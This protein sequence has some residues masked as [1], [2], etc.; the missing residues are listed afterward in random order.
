M[1]R[2]KFKEDNVRRWI[3]L[4]AMGVGEQVSY[5]FRKKV[6]QT[7]NN[8]A[9]PNRDSTSPPPRAIAPPLLSAATPCVSAPPPRLRP[10]TPRALAPPCAL[11]PP[12]QGLELPPRL[13]R[14]PHHT[15]KVTPNVLATPPRL[16]S[17][18][19]SATLCIPTPWLWERL[20]QPRGSS[21]GAKPQARRLGDK[22]WPLWRRSWWRRRPLR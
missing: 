5:Q 14:R 1:T 10:A 11:A 19:S 8:R 21:R 9:T 4:A 18:P 20:Q 12:L 13:A 6:K 7:P 3:A 2:I 16:R 22:T 15:F 17:A